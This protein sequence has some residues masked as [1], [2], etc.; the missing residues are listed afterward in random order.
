MDLN[1]SDSAWDTSE[2]RRG[3]PERESFRSCRHNNYKSEEVMYYNVPFNLAEVFDYS[4]DLDFFQLDQKLITCL[5]YGKVNE[6]VEMFKIVRLSPHFIN[7]TCHVE[8]R[9]IFKDV[10]DLIFDLTT[11]GGGRLQN[12]H[13][14]VSLMA[15]FVTQSFK[16]AMMTLI[17]P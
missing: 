11:A 12:H 6:P 10:N 15:S 9:H 1:S 3:S 4:E 8:G 2:R 13:Q 17:W 5:S 7:A 16:A 14:G